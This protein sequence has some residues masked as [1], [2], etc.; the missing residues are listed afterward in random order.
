MGAPSRGTESAG[1]T[2]A[3]RATAKTPRAP[4]FAKRILKCAV[5]CGG[6]LASARASGTTGLSRDRPLGLLITFNVKLLRSGVRRV[7]LSRR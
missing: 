6:K 7:I 2:A 5:I 3:L 1:L 4:S